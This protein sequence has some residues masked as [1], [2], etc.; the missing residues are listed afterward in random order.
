MK[1]LDMWSKADK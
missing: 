1:V